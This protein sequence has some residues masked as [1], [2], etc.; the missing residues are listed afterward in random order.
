MAVTQRPITEAALSGSS[1][2]DPLWK[3]PT[4]TVGMILEAA[5][6]RRQRQRRH[7]ERAKEMT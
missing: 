2:Q 6:L 5:R 3:R 4:Q 1:G 7:R